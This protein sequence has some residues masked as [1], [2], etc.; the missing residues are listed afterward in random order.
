[1]LYRVSHRWSRDTRWVAKFTVWDG[2]H[3]QHCSKMRRNNEGSR[4]PA[5]V[6]R[7][8]LT[9]NQPQFENLIVMWPVSN[10]L[11]HTLC[12]GEIRTLDAVP[13][14]AFIP[15]MLATRWITNCSDF[16]TPSFPMISQRQVSAQFNDFATS[17]FPM[18]S[19]RQVSQWFRNAKFPNDFA[20]SSFPMI[21]Q[22]QVSAQF[23]DFATSSF[24]IQWFRNVKFPNSRFPSCLSPLFQNEA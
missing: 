12:W 22:R 3:K 13:W 10:E 19:Q 23:N 24:P 18:I 7:T 2:M 6:S 4:E 11:L 16:T 5:S 14:H 20:T 8:G 15:P 9:W 17:S 21:S 1:M